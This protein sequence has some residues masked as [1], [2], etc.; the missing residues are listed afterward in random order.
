MRLDISRTTHS[1][2]NH[3]PVRI[4]SIVDATLPVGVSPQTF[5]YMITW[6]I[7]EIHFGDTGDLHGQIS[8]DFPCMMWNALSGVTP[9][10]SQFGKG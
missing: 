10:A 7:R 6:R 8:Q 4:R 2:K 3:D 9:N 1:A 5:R